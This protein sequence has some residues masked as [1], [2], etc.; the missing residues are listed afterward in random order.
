MFGQSPV[1]SLDSVD[2]CPPVVAYFASALTDLTDEQEAEIRELDEEVDSIC[3][4]YHSYPIALYRPRMYTSPKDNPNVPAR[5]VYE[6]DQ[7]RVATSDLLFLAAIYPSLG[8]GMELQL[9]LQ[10]CSSVILLKKAGQRLSRMVLGCPA[11]LEIV[12][13][14]DLT[15]LEGKIVEAMNRLLPIIAEFRFMQPQQTEAL[16]DSG[17]GNRIRLKREKRV[18]S[19]ERLALMVGVGTAYIES[20][21]SKPEQITNPSLQILRRIAKAL[22]TSESYLI[23]GQENLDARFA[24][25]SDSLRAFAEETGMTVGDFNLLWNEHVETHKHDLSILGVENRA[26]VGDTKYWAERYERLKKERRED[27]KLF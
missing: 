19:Q 6:I 21:E 15:S 9:A 27:G 7:E 16:A 8:A 13:Y 2:Q 5:K 1:M 26:Q 3:N 22:L 25:H 11:R 12:E 23:S 18:L 20:L 10:A 24:E 14:N 17:I 4:N